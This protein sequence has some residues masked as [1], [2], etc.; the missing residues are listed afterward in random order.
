[1]IIDFIK[2]WLYY[3]KLK[4][5]LK[6]LGVRDEDMYGTRWGYAKF[7]C[8]CGKLKDNQH[9][10]EEDETDGWTTVYDREPITK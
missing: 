9:E 8:K 3:P 6:R 10:Q 2:S 1:M 4:K 7:H 5:E